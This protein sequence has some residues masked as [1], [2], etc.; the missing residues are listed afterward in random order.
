MST[1]QRILAPAA[2]AALVSA[3]SASTSN[4]SKPAAE[5]DSSPKPAA[6]EAPAEP[7]GAGQQ[8]HAVPTK[9]QPAE[10]D[11]GGA[12]APKP[13]TPAAASGDM[14]AA[15]PTKCKDGH[16]IGDRWKDD[17]NDCWCKEGGQIVCT[18]KAC[19]QG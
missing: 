6:D 5:P 10:P 19:K 17:C 18:R 15:A 12:E 9:E 16:E 3:C 7:D 4:S 1:L 8:M 13:A 2:V 14:K 11:D